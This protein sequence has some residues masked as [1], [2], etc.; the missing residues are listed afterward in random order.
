MDS[1]T[2]TALALFA[3]A[4]VFVLLELVFGSDGSLLIL[5]GV[6][7]IGGIVFMVRSS[8]LPNDVA[9]W[10][11]PVISLGVVVAVGAIGIFVF[12][13]S[14]LGES[15]LAEPDDAE[16]APF[17]PQ[18]DERLQYIGRRGKTLTDMNPGGLVLLDGKREHAETEGAVIERGETIEVIDIRG[19]RLLVRLMREAEPNTKGLPPTSN[20]LP[21]AVVDET[22]NRMV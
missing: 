15:L 21:P 13:Q 22:R 16:T 14:S 7:A 18:G 3:L 9:W 19:H 11:Y 6:A 2:L 1:T 10:A 4:A 12:P 8:W 17:A 5:S 20:A